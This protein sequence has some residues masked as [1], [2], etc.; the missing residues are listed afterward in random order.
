[1]LSASSSLSPVSRPSAPPATADPATLSS[2]PPFDAPAPSSVVVS[3]LGTVHVLSYTPAEGEY[4][5][6]ISVRIHFQP[7]TYEP[8]FVRLIVDR[9]AIATQ[10]RELPNL[11]YGRWELT[12]TIPASESQSSYEVL[13]SVQVL[14]ENCE[15]IDT[16]MFGHYTYRPLCMSSFCQY[17]HLSL[18]DMCL[19]FQ[20]QSLQ[21]S[22]DM[23]ATRLPRPP[24]LFRRRL[25]RSVALL[26]ANFQGLLSSLTPANINH[27]CIAA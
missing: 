10:V 1:M 25:V 13:L 8:R 24:H 14:N 6:P 19:Q 15:V 3:H 18:V 12:G 26:S 16:V 11:S 9:R 2:L 5:V 27:A 21:T 20:D 7:S 17:M 22:A 4:G 23:P